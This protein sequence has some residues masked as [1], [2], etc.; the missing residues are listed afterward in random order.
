VARTD[1]RALFDEIP[2]PRVQRTRRHRLTDVLVLVLLGTV[3]GCQGWDDIR[4]FCKE[5]EAELGEVLVLAGGIPSADTLRR[6]MAAVEPAA[7]GRALT[8]WT[9]ALCETFAG[10]QIAIDGKSIRRTLEAANGESALHVVNAWVCE[11]QMVLGQYATD[12][13]SNEIT[14]IPKL[15]ELLS[16]RGSTVTI[17]AMGCQK[18]IAKLIVDKSADYIF[19]LKSNQPSLHREVLD[20]FDDATLKRLARDARSYVET[21]DKGHGRNEVRRV[22]VQRD[23]SWL[24]RSEAWPKLQSMILVEAE[25]TRRGV[26]SCERRAYISSCDEAADVLAAK[27]RGHWHV[28]NKLH[29]V[30]DVT[31]GEDHARISRKQGAESM[32]VM[33]KLAMNLLS[34]APAPFE[35]EVPSK[36]RKARIAS[37]RFSYL[38][39]V[40][41]GAE[42]E[43]PRKKSRAPAGARA[44]DKPR[45][46]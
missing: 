1:L 35:G 3:A 29:W 34:R 39:T 16:L 43:P 36:R 20:A 23:V 18:G 22:W 5:R 27:V 38:L 4:D 32:S 24:K 44:W 19:G 10:K 17:D 37:W 15:L 31:F 2:D 30:L 45:N 6:V 40:L 14:A 33:R 28:E 13:K 7:L 25:R 26:T 46:G 41:T 42:V 12:V 21:S 8:L 9:D 11:H